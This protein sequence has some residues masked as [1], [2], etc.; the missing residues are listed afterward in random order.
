MTVNQIEEDS[1]L[2]ELEDQFENFFMVAEG[3]S[4]MAIF[5]DNEYTE[6]VI[7][8]YFTPGCKRDCENLITF[9]NGEECEP[10]D[11]EKV[12][13]FAGNDD[14]LDLLS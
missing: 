7:S 5:S 4:D 8:I 10:P 13:L 9:Y 12:F 2:K 11:I 6:D 1:T 3:P 14:A